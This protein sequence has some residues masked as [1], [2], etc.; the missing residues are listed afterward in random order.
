MK[1][2]VKQGKW[3]RIH[4]KQRDDKK[5]EKMINGGS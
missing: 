4:D 5:D 3:D 2:G 1:G